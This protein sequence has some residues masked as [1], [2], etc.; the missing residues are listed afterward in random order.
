MKCKN[1]LLSLS[2][3]AGLSLVGCAQDVNSANVAN[4]GAVTKDE[5][6]NIIVILTDDH[7]YADVGFNNSPDLKTPNLD[8]L[9]YGGTIFTSA[10]VA[11]PFCGPSRAALMT[12]RYPHEYGAQFNLPRKGS[13][14]GLPK[15]ETFISKVLQNAGYYTGAIGKWH[16]GEHADHHPNVRGFDEFY[17][18]LAGGHYYFPEKYEPEYERLVKRGKH[19]V[20]MYYW[21]LEYN[22][23]EV[24]EPEYLTDGLSREASTF[25]EKASKKDKPF[26]LYLAYNAPHTPLEAKEEDMALFPNITDKNRK[27]YAGMVYAVDR[28]VG[29]LVD[30]LKRTGEYDNTLIVF[31]SD[32]GGKTIKGAN[33]YPLRRGKG[34]AYEGGIRVPMM[35]HWPKEIKGGNTF[36]HPVSALDFYPMFAALGNAKIPE[37]KD[38]DG[39][40][41]WPKIQAG[42]PT[43]DTKMIY[44]MRHQKGFSETSGRLGDYKV[45][46]TSKEGPWQ[47][48]NVQTD[49]GEHNDLA[50]QKPWLLREMVSQIEIWSWDHQQ[51]KWFH[52]WDAG[53]EWHEQNM[54]RF[55]ETF[56]VGQAD[57]VLQA[58][59]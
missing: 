20:N 50:A 16:L 48:F 47:L 51:P 40:N 26:F 11:H 2:V 13:N 45:V 15:E 5:R 9:A 6:P 19:N 33:N 28:G 7:G 39:Y 55:H 14:Q 1:V 38:L 43:H 29:K 22:G 37:G 8:Q 41:V 10:Y 23:Q 17:G 36:H 44:A 31:L 18:F 30:T 35:F 53:G 46:R 32:N 57:P 56:K 27:I 49:P 58:Q 25:V 4:N 52:I 12:G 21:P 42:K 34:S 59:P 54:P 24:R 3:L